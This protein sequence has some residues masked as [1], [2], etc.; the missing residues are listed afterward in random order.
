PREGL[1]FCNRLFAI[2][3][4]M[5]DSSPEERLKIRTEQSRAVLDAFLAW[6]RMNR[7][8]VLPKSK[9]GEAIAYCLNQ[10]AKLEAFM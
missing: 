2:E 9:L 8:R 5:K 3:R 4:D 6:L 10:W 1:D 7:S